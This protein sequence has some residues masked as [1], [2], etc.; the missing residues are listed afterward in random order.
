[1]VVPV[2]ETH[3]C[4]RVPAERR[5]RVVHQSLQRTTTGMVT[6]AI[7][8]SYMCLSIANEIGANTAVPQHYWKGHNNSGKVQEMWVYVGLCMCAGVGVRGA[9]GHLPLPDPNPCQCPL[10]T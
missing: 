1:M 6:C 7:S 3:L 8:L 2:A 5:E 4:M 9:D 10:H